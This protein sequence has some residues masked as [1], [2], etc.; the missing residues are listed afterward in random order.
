MKPFENILFVSTEIKG[1][2]DALTRAAVLAR[3]DGARLTVAS[4]VDRVPSWGSLLLRQL[5]AEDLQQA[6]VEQRRGDLDVLVRAVAE[7]LDVER[8][9]LVG[10]PF[11]EI[12]RAVLKDGYDLVVKAGEGH[13]AGFLGSTDMHLMRKCP[14]PLWIDKPGRH[15]AYRRVLAAVDPTPEDPVRD[16]LDRLILDHAAEMAAL[17]GAELHVLHA[18]NLVGEAALTGPFVNMAKEDVATLGRAARRRA[19]TELDA[20]LRRY[21]PTVA[22]WRAHLLKGAASSVIPGFA[23]RGRTDLIVLGT[24]GRTGLPG[25]FIGNTAENVLR[26]VG[27]SVL[28]MKPK[29]FAS[30]VTPE[31]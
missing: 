17:F 19:Q 30:P 2:F 22:G 4:V 1:E 23:R 16:N 9:V 20:L 11:I 29:G 26:Q 28:A 3:K 27:C 15:P 6:V 13:P 14:V 31:D 25:F 18:W 8:R 12:V 10:T 5:A 7:D 24:V 21:P